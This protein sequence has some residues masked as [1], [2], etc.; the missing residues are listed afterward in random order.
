MKQLPRQLSFICQ[1]NV[2]PQFE[3]KMIAICWLVEE[4]CMHVNE[5]STTLRLNS[6]KSLVLNVSPGLILG[7]LWHLYFTQKEMLIELL[8]LMKYMYMYSMEWA[9]ENVKVQS[10]KC[11]HTSSACT[12]SCIWFPTKR[13]Y[14]KIFSPNK[15]LNYTIMY[16]NV[17]CIWIV[18][19]M[20]VKSREKRE[21]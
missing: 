5:Q 9:V 10:N 2:G 15:K 11:V 16:T 20:H 19:I 4:T 1:L 18:T 14:F 12:L 21:K 7:I 17:V 6:R 8:T 3:T 13:E